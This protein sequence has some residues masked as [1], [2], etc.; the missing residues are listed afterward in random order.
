MGVILANRGRGHFIYAFHQA[1]DP[2]I[3]EL[4]VKTLCF[5]KYWGVE[6]EKEKICHPTDK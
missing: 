2:E 3:L 4:A 5:D 1:S 6:H